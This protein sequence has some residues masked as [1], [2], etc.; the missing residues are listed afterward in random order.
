MTPNSEAVQYWNA[1]REQTEAELSGK[2][3]VHPDQIQQRERSSWKG[4]PGFSSLDRAKRNQA[5]YRERS[6]EE[7]RTP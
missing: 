6:A 7:N 1:T 3:Q 5:V 2:H 4:L